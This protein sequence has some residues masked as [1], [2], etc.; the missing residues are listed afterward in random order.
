MNSVKILSLNRDEVI[1]K[2]EDSINDLVKKRREILKVI[3]FGSL[4]RENYTPYSDADILIIIDDKAKIPQKIR[5]RIPY[6]FIDDA[7]ISIDVFPY[8]E[9]E[10]QKK[11]SENNFFVKNAVDN[12]KVIFSR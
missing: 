2:L 3:L 4:T 9:K 8:K 11:I 10:I 12:G 6:Y 5:D 1:N 7:P